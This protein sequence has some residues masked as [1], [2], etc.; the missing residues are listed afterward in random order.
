MAEAMLRHALQT[1]GCADIEVASAGTWAHFG[2]RATPEAIQTVAAMGI[3]LGAHRSRPLDPGEL[4]AADLVVAMT[5]V[6]VRDILQMAP[7]VEPKLRL[8][9]ELAELDVAD[10]RGSSP[11]ERLAA[12]LRATRPPS[13]RSLDLDDPIGLPLHAYERCAADVGC[14]IEVLADVLCRPAA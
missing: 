1:R 11:A 4:A 3:D 14:G 13:R 9:K 10:V 6:H 12:L 8:L 7:R 2:S 5:S